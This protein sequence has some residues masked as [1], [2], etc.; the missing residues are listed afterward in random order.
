MNPC[1]PGHLRDARDRP[2]NIRRC[3]LHQIRQL[4]NDHHDVGQRVWNDHFLL[5]WRRRRCIAR[6]VMPHTRHLFCLVIRRKTQF[7]VQPRKRQRHPWVIAIVF[8]LFYEEL[9]FGLHFLSW[10]LAILRRSNLGRLGFLRFLAIAG[11]ERLK[12][13]A[14]LLRKDLIAILHLLH[15]PAQC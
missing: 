4:I 7:T 11:V 10:S 6:P 9:R 8:L 12:V 15:H 5:P 3:R 1:R 14:G 2:L 13:P